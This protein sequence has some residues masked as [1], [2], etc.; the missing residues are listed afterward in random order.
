MT[1]IVER[2]TP[3]GTMGTGLVRTVREGDFPCEACVH[4]CKD[5]YAI[6][7]SAAAFRRN[8]KVRITVPNSVV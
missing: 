6:G 2:T 7:I 1:S 3:V 4:T 5:I 8:P